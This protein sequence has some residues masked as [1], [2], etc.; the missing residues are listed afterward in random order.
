MTATEAGSATSTER[1]DAFAGRLFE[2]TLGAFDLLTIHLGITLG[3]Y[4]TLRDHG[5]ATPVEL[6]QRAGIDRRYAR[7][8]LEQQAVTDILDVDD[9]GAG[10]DARRYSL[11]PG[12]AEALLDPESP[13][14]SQSMVRFVLSASR[15]VPALADAYRAGAG[16][17]AE[18]YPD[19]VLA[20]ELANRPIFRHTLTTDW[21][22][23]SPAV[24]A[25]R[26]RGG[27]RVADVASGAGWAA[28]AI[29]RAYPGVT[30]DGLDI[31]AKAIERARENAAAEG[32]A[33][34]RVR[35]HV[36]DAGRPELD[37]KFDL[38]TIFEAVHDLSRPVEVLEAARRLLAPGGVALVVDENVAETFTAPGDEVERMMY[39]YSTLFCLPQSRADLPSVATGTVMRP[40]T[41]HRYATEAGFARVSVLPV[42]HDFFRLY[43]LEP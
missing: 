17:A 18:A 39:G 36:V 22:P 21:L 19:H 3:L 24:E 35:F 26:R 30:V 6:A 37:G 31:D 42:Q 7:E 34:D 11:P 14:A 41:L 20:Q 28:I 15:T 25:R 32:M 16:V 13:A 4:E 33:E 1:R 2:A 12:H 43:R 29:A 40:A 23:A 38:V 9:V 8:W 5:P 27:A 10:P